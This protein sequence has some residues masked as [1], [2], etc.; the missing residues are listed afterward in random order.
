MEAGQSRDKS[1]PNGFVEVS[2]K[3]HTRDSLQMHRELHKSITDFP[4][5]A[6][7]ADPSPCLFVSSTRS[8]VFCVS[9]KKCVMP[10][11]GKHLMDHWTLVRVNDFEIVGGRPAR[12]IITT[13]TYTLKVI[14]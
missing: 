8:V 6:F 1:I 10:L 4:L 13:F 5:L 12:G 11:V 2:R 3:I 9:V 14:L 7:G